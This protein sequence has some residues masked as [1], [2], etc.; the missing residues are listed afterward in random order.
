MNQTMNLSAFSIGLG[1]LACTF[2]Y[3]FIY[4]CYF[5][6]SVFV[7]DDIYYVNCFGVYGTGDE[8]AHDNS[9][10]YHGFCCFCLILT[11]YGGVSYCD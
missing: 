8:V 10:H 5:T 11:F 6:F 7:V 4:F 9:Y 1:Y 3:C 2:D